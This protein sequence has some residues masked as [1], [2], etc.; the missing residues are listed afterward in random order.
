MPSLK[1]QER[2]ALR[3]A[4]VEAFQSYAVLRRMGKDQLDFDLNTRTDASTG[5]D[6]GADELITAMDE[7]IGRTGIVRLIDAARAERPEHPALRAI[8]QRFIQTT[9]PLGDVYLVPA[10]AGKAAT[11]GGLER[12]IVEAAGFPHF[13]DFI[14]KLGL[15]EFRVCLV[16]YQLPEGRHVY[17]TGFLV[18]NDLVMTNDHV[19]SLAR[20]NALPGLA[21]EL[22][23]GYRS[24]EAN[25][26]RYS[27]AGQD[28]LVASDSTLDYAIL[29][30]QGTP[31]SDALVANGT[32]E[33]GTFKLVTET[34]QTELPLI[35]LQHPYD[36][37]DA[38]PST[39]RMTIGFA[40]PQ[41]DTQPAHVL[42]HS[43]NT[44]EG[45]SGSPVFSGKMDLIALHNW[46][47]P[48]HNEAILCSAIKQHLGATGNEDL[49]G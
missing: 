7:K 14:G 21:I 42:R 16:S 45:S 36:K 13:D 18:A 38:S 29:R 35:I 46:G 47:G 26:V 28:W 5:T 22:A 25:P 17:G 12:V 40:R 39:L 27:L 44:S 1:G 32:K 34:P 24:K 33:R 37:L 3:D 41:Q 10:V 4:L 9:D 11:L 23:F 20:G 15:A 48:K 6:N 19:I 8:E 30:V 49:L 43:A 2:K 31:G